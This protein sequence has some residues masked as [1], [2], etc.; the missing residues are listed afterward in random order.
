MKM[1]TDTLLQ[2][3]L[4]DHQSLAAIM[5]RQQHNLHKAIGHGSLG[6]SFDLSRQWSS[7]VNKALGMNE[8]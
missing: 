8:L 2:W 4:R 3:S 6:M 1:F 7:N 5:C